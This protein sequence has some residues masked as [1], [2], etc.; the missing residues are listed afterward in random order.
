MTVE[1][2]PLGAT[3]VQVSRFGLGTMVLGR[4]G[5]P[6]PR[7]VCPDHPAGDRRRDQPH[8]HRRRLRRRGERGDRRAGDC[9]TARRRRAGD[10]VPWAMGDDVNR[11]G[12]S[13]RWVMRAI[14]ESLRRLGVDHVDLYQI[15]R[16]DPATPIEE[17]VAPSTISSAPARSATG[18]RRRSPPTRSSKR[19]GQPLGATPPDRTPSSRRT[20]SSA[21]TSN[22]TSCRRVSATASG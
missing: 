10:Q 21:G 15:H 16:P 2:R 1:Y 3:G 12:N 14:D 4:V 22:A 7:R 5:Q 9:R 20:R 8:R 11:R 13:R 6:R 17:T 18:V 19:D